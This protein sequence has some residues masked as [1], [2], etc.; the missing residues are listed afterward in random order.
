MNKE[1]FLSLADE[2]EVRFE[3]ADPHGWI[4]WKGTDVCVDIH[5][6]CGEV[7]HFDGP[8]MYFVCC[9]ACGEVYEANGNIELIPRGKDFQ[10]PCVQDAE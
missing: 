9:P 5:C 10:G 6:A 1:R 2:R 3:P 7:S 4:Q 8:F